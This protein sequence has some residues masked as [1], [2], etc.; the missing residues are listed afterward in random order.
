MIEN[1]Y[2]NIDRLIGVKVGKVKQSI[3]SIYK[4]K[5]AISPKFSYDFPILLLNIYDYHCSYWMLDWL[6]ALQALALSLC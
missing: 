2:I 1:Y 3:Y 5:T 6:Q 4:T